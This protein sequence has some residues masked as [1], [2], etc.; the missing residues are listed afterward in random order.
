LEE[1]LREVTIEEDFLN[2]QQDEHSVFA[3]CSVAEH[4][5][6]GELF[7]GAYRLNEGP[8]KGLK[9]LER[10]IQ[11]LA[12]SRVE[13][14]RELCRH[15][16]PLLCPT[17]LPTF[18]KTGIDD[19]I[20]YELN[21]ELLGYQSLGRYLE[22][23]GG[24]I[25]D[26]LRDIVRRVIAGSCFGPNGRFTHGHLHRGNILVKLDATGRIADIKIIDWKLVRRKKLS[27][28][29]DWLKFVSGERTHLRGAHL[30]GVDFEGADLEGIDLEGADLGLTLFGWGNL[31]R[32]ILDKASLV[33]VIM[34]ET[35][36]RGASLKKAILTNLASRYLDMRGADLSGAGLTSVALENANLEGAVCRDTD[37]LECNLKGA[38]LNNADL[39]DA[40]IASTCLIGAKFEMGIFDCSKPPHLEDALFSLDRAPEFERRGYRVERF[41]PGIWRRCSISER[42]VLMARLGGFVIDVANQGFCLVTSLQPNPD[43][44]LRT[45]DEATLTQI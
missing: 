37:F 7:G 44:D 24:T 39:N 9:I 18:F 8:A 2:L 43:L 23:T 6:A 10:D 42:G 3:G 17:Y 29:A 28:F 25:D 40:S 21:L 5:Q 30:R 15:R 12:M 26:G 27:R 36:L 31:R 38:N 32:T 16:Y 45:A 14:I 41:E 19:I 35:D 20:C 13:D 11:S 34:Y 4:I 1:A 22:A 33:G